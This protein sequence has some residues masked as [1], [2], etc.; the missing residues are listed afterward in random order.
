M[1]R[2]IGISAIL[3]AFLATTTAL[4]AAA[5][6]RCFQLCPQAKVAKSE[7]VATVTLHVAG[8]MKSRSGAT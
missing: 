2:M 3:V 8:M 7:R 6:K 1:D 5:G 4:P